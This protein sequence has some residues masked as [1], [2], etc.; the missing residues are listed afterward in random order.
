M[1]I[2]PVFK[3]EAE[4]QVLAVF[5]EDLSSVPSTHIG[6]LTATSVPADLMPS[7]LEGTYMHVCM[8]KDAYTEIKII[9]NDGYCTC[10]K[11]EIPGKDEGKVTEWQKLTT[12]PYK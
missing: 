9:L 5:E 1:E 2:S 3:K 6:Q 8:H 12:N 10:E 4:R 11:G 7:D